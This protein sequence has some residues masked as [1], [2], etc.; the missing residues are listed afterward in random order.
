MP[1]G[2]ELALPH[3]QAVWFNDTAASGRKAG[4]TECT[5]VALLDFA[6][7]C[8]DEGFVYNHDVSITMYGAMFLLVA[9][10]WFTPTQSA[11]ILRSITK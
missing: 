11:V 4:L 6:P 2:I 10:H 3:R 9:S 5:A 7:V 8:T 1:I